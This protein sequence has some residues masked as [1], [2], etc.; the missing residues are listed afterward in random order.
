MIASLLAASSPAATSVFLDSSAAGNNAAVATAYGDSIYLIQP[1][2]NVNPAFKVEDGKTNWSKDNISGFSSSTDMEPLPIHQVPVISY[3]GLHYIALGV[4]FNET[5]S[6]SDF[7]VVNLMLWVGPASASTLAVA[8]QN[9]PNIGALTWATSATNQM[10]NSWESGIRTMENNPANSAQGIDLIYQQNAN[11]QLNVAGDAM[12]YG[13]DPK[14]VY[15]NGL[16]SLGSNEAD[17]AILVPYSVL[18]G[19]NS[20]EVLYV[21]LQTGSMTD[22]GSDRVGFIDPTTLVNGGYLQQQGV[23]ISTTFVQP[24]TSITVPEPSSA[25]LGLGALALCLVRRRRD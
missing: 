3:G 13:S 25:A 4:D 2:I 9:D 8:I 11:P 18:I 22:G 6:S 16:S 24:G 14:R 1:G 19:R 21:G 12:P 20:S 23:P 17:I 15:S 7:D 10:K 5:G